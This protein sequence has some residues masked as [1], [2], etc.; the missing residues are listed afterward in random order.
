MG[1]PLVP[2]PREQSGPQG[3][4]SIGIPWGGSDVAEI[5]DAKKGKDWIVLRLPKCLAVLTRDEL[6]ACL[7]MNPEV[8]MKAVRRGKIAMRRRRREVSASYGGLRESKKMDTLGP[9]G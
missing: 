9:R 1:F 8:F 7:A 2:T 5:I 4:K 6:L 3:Y